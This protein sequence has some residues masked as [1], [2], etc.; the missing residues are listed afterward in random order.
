MT[1]VRTLRLT[2]KLLRVRAILGYSDPPSRL[3]GNRRG[4]RGKPKPVCQ[5]CKATRRKHTVSET[6]PGR[7]HCDE[8]GRRVTPDGA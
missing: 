2:L 4:D 5:Y 3:P 8:C 7:Y 6:A 1:A